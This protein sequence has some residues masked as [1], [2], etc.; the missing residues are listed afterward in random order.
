MNEKIFS[1]E[2]LES[3]KDKSEAE[4]FHILQNMGND[5][6]LTGIEKDK[7]DKVKTDIND[8]I[9]ENIK[10]DI[11][12]QLNKWINESLSESIKN[13]SDQALTEIYNS[14]LNIAKQ[15]YDFMM[16]QFAS[17]LY[18]YFQL[19]KENE[20]LEKNS[21]K[22]FNDLNKVTIDAK[23]FSDMYNYIIG[24]NSGTKSD[25]DLIN[26][27]NQFAQTVKNNKYSFKEQKISPED[28][29]DVFYHPDELLDILR[30]LHK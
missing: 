27:L 16:K 28:L 5:T 2:Q 12:P 11:K 10:Q 22:N 13:I 25:N 30:I 6:L 26:K 1:N 7:L 20:T 17:L 8:W 19:K 3:I 21:N 14:N 15:N 4:I 23:L 18:K 9:V 29:I 24:H